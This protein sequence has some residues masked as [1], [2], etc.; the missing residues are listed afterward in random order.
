MAFEERALPVLDD[1]LAQLALAYKLS[2]LE[3]PRP[4]DW[5]SYRIKPPAPRADVEKVEACHGVRLPESFR[6]VLM[7]FSRGI[8]FS[9]HL[10]SFI[11]SR[12][13]PDRGYLEWDLDTLCIVD[14]EKLLFDED[15]R[16]CADALFGPGERKIFF[17]S[18]NVVMDCGAGATEAILQIDNQHCESALRLAPGFATYID[19]LTALGCPDLEFYEVSEFL[20]SDGLDPECAAGL[21]LRRLLG[22][23]G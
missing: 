4:A 8:E 16:P 17:G 7:G 10:P 20:G 18:Q 2:R 13:V 23:V 19:R 9:W 15:E 22:L 6:D 1:P 12:D 3:G 11:P 14:R 5:M 21:K